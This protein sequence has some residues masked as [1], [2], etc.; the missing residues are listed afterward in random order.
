MEKNFVKIKQ[1]EFYHHLDF[2]KD[3]L[4]CY[5]VEIKD[6][7]LV[8]RAGYVESESLP[9]ADVK[10]I[11]C[12]KNTRYYLV[13][14]KICTLS[15]NTFT[16]VSDIS[17]S[18][19]FNCLSILLNGVEKPFIFN[20]NKGLVLGVEKQ[21]EIVVQ[22]AQFNEVC[23]GRIFQADSNKI[24]FSRPFD[25]STNSHSLKVEYFI[26]IK[27]KYGD[28][29]GMAS[30]DDQLFVF[31][32]N[33]ILKIVQ[34]ENLD[35]KIEKLNF[36]VSTVM[37]K[38]VGKAGSYII[39][40]SNE[41]L[42]KF[43]GKKVE[44]IKINIGKKYCFNSNPRIVD[45]YYIGLIKKQNY[46]QEVIIVDSSK[47][48]FFK[49]NEVDNILFSKQGGYAVDNKNKKLLTFSLDGK[50]P[51]NANMS[52]K[53]KKYAS[54]VAIIGFETEMQGSC[55]V[56]FG[57]LS[58]TRYYNLS[59]LENKV[60]CFIPTGF[61]TLYIDNISEDFCMESLKIKMRKRGVKNAVH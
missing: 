17:F 37:E 61:G 12:Y 11:M 45:R 47:N 8:R 29:C 1:K 48:S 28:I 54:D 60:K 24:Y 36:P 27:S 57:Y 30:I 52:Y 35:I 44:D 2:T 46:L 43:D 56:K 58:G 40:A 23:M 5:N 16:P 38:S 34:D 14:N 20:S 15:G 33:T 22:F 50:S 41:E 3:L 7:V 49:I 13:D 10:D 19:K 4:H 51:F 9:N 53:E 31:T 59:K 39:F 55:R 42:Y 32:K 6:G 21:P 25:C 26:E 18:G